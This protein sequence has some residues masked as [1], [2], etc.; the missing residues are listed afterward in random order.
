MNKA[1]SQDLRRRVVREYYRIPD[2]RRA[3]LK[4]GYSLSSFYRINRTAQQFGL[5]YLWE[6]LY[7]RRATTRRLTDIVEAAVIVY[8]TGHPRQGPSAIARALRLLG[9][10]I[11]PKGVRGVFS[12]YLIPNYYAVQERYRRAHKKSERDCPM[13]QVPW[14][15]QA[16]LP[17]LAARWPSLFQ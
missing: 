13:F 17:P 15:P 2:L 4:V 9:I 10:V 1:E 8:S 14:R 11:S 3:C 16:P 6:G 5:R 7:R 12:R